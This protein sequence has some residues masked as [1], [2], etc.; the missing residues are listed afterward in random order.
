LLDNKK[1][2]TQPVT[3]PSIEFDDE[4]EERGAEPIQTSQRPGEV[5]IKEGEA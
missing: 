5:H 3:P 4:E 1:K 2:R